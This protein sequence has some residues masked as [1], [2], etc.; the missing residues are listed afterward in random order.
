MKL[1]QQQRR[2]QL[3]LHLQ[4]PAQDV[5][6][7]NDGAGALPS[8]FE[9][10]T[11]DEVHLPPEACKEHLSLQQEGIDPKTGILIPP[12]KIQQDCRAI[13]QLQKQRDAGK[14]AWMA[15]MHDTH[16]VKQARAASKEAAGGGLTQIFDELHREQVLVSLGV[17]CCPN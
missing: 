15:A 4:G 2:Q 6:L 7:K 16:D 9:G 17:V 8:I 13:D 10:R 12:E 1:G 3:I 5:A 14:K 11:F